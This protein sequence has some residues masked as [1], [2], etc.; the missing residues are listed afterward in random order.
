[1]KR[2]LVREI[3]IITIAIL[4]SLIIVM[5][6]LDFI[7]VRKNLI[8]SFI[9]KGEA[10]INISG[11]SME[12]GVYAED[13]T[14]LL[15]SVMGIMK[16]KEVIFVGIYNIK[17]VPIFEKQKTKLRFKL[18]LEEISSLSSENIY[19]KYLKGH[20]Y[21]ELVGKIFSSSSAEGSNDKWKGK[22]I[23]YVGILLSLSDLNRNISSVIWMTI[24]AFFIL[25]GVG[26]FLTGHR[27]MKVVEPLRIVVSVMKDI[28]QR[29]GDL[30]KRVEVKGPK[31]ITD[32]GTYFNEFMDS[33]EKLTIENKNMIVKLAS[34][35][36]ELSSSS[37]QMTASSEEISSTM[38][39]ISQA[40]EK[41]ASEVQKAVDMSKKALEVVKESVQTALEAK[42]VSKGIHTLAMEGEKAANDAHTRMDRITQIMDELKEVVQLVN[43]KAKNINEIT[44]AVNS[45]SKRT[46]I[47]A[48]N[49][50]IEAARAGEYGRGFAVVAEEVRKLAMRSQNS[51]EEIGEIT[52][53]ISQTVNSMVEKAA[54]S[55]DEIEEGK[56]VIYKGADY[57]R[58]IAEEIGEITERVVKIS[59]R[60]KRGEEEVNTITESIESVAAISEE[61]AASSQEVSAAVEQLVA[62][63]Q[64]LSSVAQEI[65][66]FSDS[67]GEL[68]TGLKT[69]EG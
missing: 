50:T 21:L 7:I 48:L 33:L 53:E 44:E 52:E 17:G 5:G 28:S 41:Q 56:K 16:E 35:A 2:T 14:L 45:I 55:I 6:I 8:A 26:G 47:L 20:R 36:E 37:E 32:L 11:P 4:S 61:N 49:A 64:E 58:K 42:D 30:T 25:V 1:M 63:I 38:Q 13:S 68:V 65:A 3:A 40:S 10:L 57:L 18:S 23:G 24:I 31:E 12:L 22:P 43:V 62:S 34:Q 15:P 29:H 69:S 60:N 66:R 51:A 19:I 59:Q 27:I 54:D 67:I 9:S 39:S 46:N